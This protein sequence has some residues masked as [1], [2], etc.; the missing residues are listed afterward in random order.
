[1]SQ[2]GSDSMYNLRKIMLVDLAPGTY[3]M[4]PKL[5]WNSTTMKL[6]THAT[7]YRSERPYNMTTDEFFVSTQGYVNLRRGFVIPQHELGTYGAPY[8]HAM[9]DLVWRSYRRPRY[10]FALEKYARCMFTDSALVYAHRIGSWM[11]DITKSHAFT[12]NHSDNA[13]PQPRCGTYMEIL[14]GLHA[15]ALTDEPSCKRCQRL[16]EHA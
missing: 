15:F 14:R 12:I 5:T 6:N 3:F 2:C 16:M 11:S 13:F 10:V 1:M 9:N 8:E 7:I 4:A